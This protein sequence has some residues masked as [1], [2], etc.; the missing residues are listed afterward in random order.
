[1]LLNHDRR[2]A[3]QAEVIVLVDADMVT[4]ARPSRHTDRSKPQPGASSR[5]KSPRSASLPY[6][7]RAPRT[8]WDV[9]GHMCARV[10]HSTAGSRNSFMLELFNSSQPR[11]VCSSFSGGAAS[12]PSATH[13]QLR[14]TLKQD[15]LSARHEALTCPRARLQL[16]ARL[17]PS[18]GRRGPHVSTAHSSSTT[19]QNA[20][21]PFIAP[22]PHRGAPRSGASPGHASQ[23]LNHL[24]ARYRS[25]APA[26]RPT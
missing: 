14:F 12:R 18:F 24:P 2:D 21:I 6:G 22:P 23:L 4:G 9:T 17:A 20:H 7:V 16:G 13:Y 10:S 5:S 11:L 3:D 25:P 26:L 1:M 19:T 15:T 8:R